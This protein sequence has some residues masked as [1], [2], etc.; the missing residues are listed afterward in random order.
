MRNIKILHIT[1]SFGWSGG[2][3]QC[4]FLA[5]ELRKKGYTNIIACPLNG[6][7]GKKANQSGF[8]IIN[9][10]PDGKVDLK[11]SLYFSKIY[12][13][14]KFDIVHAHHPKAHNMA[15]I[16]KIFSKNK[17]VLIVSRRVIHKLPNNILA[18][19]KYK[20]KYIDAYIAV[21][22]YVKNMLVEYGIEENKVFTV[23]SGVDKSKYFYKEK[24]LN[25]KRSLGLQENDFV[26]SLIG[27]FSYDKGQ[28]ILISAL[29]IL[30]NKGF[31][32]KV[33]FAGR[34]TDS[35]KIKEMFSKKLN[36]NDG[37]FL[38]LRDDVE[39]IL[40]ITDINVNSS[41]SDALSGSLRE[42]L[43]CGIPSV[44][45]DIG[46][47][48]EILKHGFNGFLFPVGDYISLA[49]KLE[50]LIK[51]KDLRNKFSKNSLDI[52]DEKFTIKSMAE[53]TLEIYLKFINEEK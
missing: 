49:E 23:Y 9:F 40:N 8:D 4:F 35:S 12:N 18:K 13:E 27:A 51:D 31:N 2:A 33:I 37:I 11:T 39:R 41:M 15:L 19:W 7:L 36:I 24:D 16:A 6:D 14:L 48:K 28:H 38:G 43:A 10:S 50:I 53:K 21:C 26:I 42:A 5:Q 34:N 46:G 44:A 1:E 25:F 47:N 20:T 3:A 32:F 30:K 17:P 45:A 52:V 29:E 22:D